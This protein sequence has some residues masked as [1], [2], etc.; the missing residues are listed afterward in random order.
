VRDA[1]VSGVSIV[2]AGSFNPAIIHPLWLSEKKLIP[3]NI[4]EHAVSQQ[5]TQGTIVTPELAVF[6]AD[7]LAVQV[8]QQQA[9][10]STVDEARQHELRDFVRG[11]FTLLPETPVDGLGINADSHFRAESQ[12]AWHAFGD[13]FMPKDFW[14]PLFESDGWRSRS[15]GKGRVGMRTMTV[16]AHR[17][18]E[19]LPG[20]VRVELAPSVR[21]VPNGVYVGI[22]AHF[23]L[24][25]SNERR[26]T[27][28]TAARVLQEQWEDTRTQQARLIAQILQAV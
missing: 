18:D 5:Q 19:Y 1:E 12:D 21:L 9:V 28:M 13:M 15:D 23:Q 17:T 26:E 22:N 25:K 11:L 16:E 7:W 8:T 6:V 3:E 4:A 10:F 24:S 2:G 14:E 20:F 27:A